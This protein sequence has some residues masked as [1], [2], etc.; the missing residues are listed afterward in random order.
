[1][2]AFRRTVRL[3]PDTPYDLGFMDVVTTAE[4][5]AALAVSL[6]GAY[7]HVL[8]PATSFGK[9]AAPRIG[10]V[11]G[12]LSVK[13]DSDLMIITKQGQIIRIESASIRQAGRST[14]GVRLVNVEEGDQVAAA[15]LI[16]DTEVANG[17]QGDLPLQ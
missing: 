16:P 2:S 12:I 6:A 14:Q 5:V 10:K 11:V 1:M 8:L 17:D 13:E 15:S 4:R 9:D 7:S 3:K